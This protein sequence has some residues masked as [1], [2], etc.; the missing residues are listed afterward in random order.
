M[1]R[2]NLLF[3]LGGLIIGAVAAA[4]LPLQAQGERKPTENRAVP[5]HNRDAD[6]TQSASALPIQDALLKPYNFRFSRPTTLNDLSQRLRHDL[7]APVV[8][9]RAALDRLEIK[10]EETVSLE[11]HGV[12]LKTG[13][14]LLLDQVRLSYRV[15]PEDNLLILTDKEG[16]EEPVEQV[17]AELRELH[18][19]VHDIQDAVDELRELSGAAGAEGAKVRKP[20][21]IE[22]MPDNDGQKSGGAPAPRPAPKSD[23]GPKPPGNQPTRPRTRL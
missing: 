10:P 21:I 17:L 23:S 1:T 8:L 5:Q 11:L 3:V 19:D 2:Q 9:D 18:R 4:H 13:L 16:S 20:T 7:G 22:E 15:V 12:R 6:S 14:K